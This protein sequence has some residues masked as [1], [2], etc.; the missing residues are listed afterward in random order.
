MWCDPLT[1]EG[2]K[3]GRP[4]VS[5]TCSL[6]GGSRGW[7][8]KGVVPQRLTARVLGR[9]KCLPVLNGGVNQIRICCVLHSFSGPPGPL[10]K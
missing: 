4:L 8:G 1:R 2:P 7:W 9:S 10:I 5:S 3:P 6:V